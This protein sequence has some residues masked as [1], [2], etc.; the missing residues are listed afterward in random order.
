MWV[1][2]LVHCS[3]WLYL[4][5]SLYVL[6]AIIACMYILCSHTYSQ[7]YISTPASY[8]CM[9]V[10]QVYFLQP[11]PN[12]RRNLPGACCM[13]V[14]PVMLA[15]REWLYDMQHGSCIIL[16]QLLVLI[17]AAISGNKD[18][19][20]LF[21]VLLTLLNAVL[22]I[23]RSTVTFHTMPVNMIDSQNN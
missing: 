20:L 9:K 18:K 13:C 22:L 17:R 6:G 23:C 4:C 15:S 16:K 12:P 21:L 19:V 8:V 1:Q 11:I 5:V 3:A 14:F 2:L 10:R 7:E